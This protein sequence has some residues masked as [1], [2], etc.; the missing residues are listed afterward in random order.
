MREYL[1]ELKLKLKN[2]EVSERIEIEIKKCR[3]FC[4]SCFSSPSLP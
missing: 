3:G 1:K 4:F 2:A